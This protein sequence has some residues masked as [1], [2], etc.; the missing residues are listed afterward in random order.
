MKEPEATVEAAGLAGEVRQAIREELDQVLPH[1]LGAL[2]R[3]RAFDA[4]TA[5]LQE[6]ERRL[7]AHR[8]RPMAVAV[9]RV[10]CQLRRL[11]F[12]GD[13]RAALDAELVKVLAEAGFEEF[14]AVGERFDPV[15][16]EA[17]AGAAEGGRAVVVELYATGLG[18][19]G[20]VVKAAQ[21][22]VG[23]EAPSSK[24]V[25]PA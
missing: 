18:C 5:R 1:L 23:A 12:D 8:E 6:T 14:G 3:D 15:R 13:A 7:E 22:R 21:V 4:L 17:L 25:S 20:Q 10:L 16:H 11:A 9:H 2:K 24:E 19:F